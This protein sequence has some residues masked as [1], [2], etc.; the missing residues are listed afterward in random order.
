MKHC[1]EIEWK[2]THLHYLHFFS[3]F[4]FL[5]ILSSFCTILIYAFIFVLSK[6]FDVEHCCCFQ[7]ETVSMVMFTKLENA[8]GH[9]P[10]FDSGAWALVWYVYLRVCVYFGLYMLWLKSYLD[11]FKNQ[12]NKIVFRK[13][14]RR[15]WEIGLQ[16][17]L[18]D[19]KLN[20]SVYFLI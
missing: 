2:N 12:L 3:T 11:R 19:E 16:N 14:Y 17:F 7:M 15:R 10:D 1:W 20:D 18:P 6:T 9:F 4:F 8:F 5:V 13:V